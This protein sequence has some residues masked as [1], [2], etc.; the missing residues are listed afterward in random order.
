MIYIISKFNKIKEINKNSENFN[1]KALLFGL[2]TSLQVLVEPSKEHCIEESTGIYEPQ[3]FISVVSQV[4]SVHFSAVVSQTH[5]IKI[6]GEYP[7][8]SFCSRTK[9]Q[10]SNSS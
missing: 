6:L 3:L 10:S 8:Q 1:C 7:L 9:K 2:E 4:V 5:L